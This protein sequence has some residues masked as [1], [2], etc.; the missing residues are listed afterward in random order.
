MDWTPLL[1][2]AAPGLAV[3]LLFLATWLVSLPLRNASIA[4]IVW[5]PGFVVV[6]WVAWAVGTG[7]GQRGGEVRLLLPLLTTVWGIRLAF[8]IARRNRGKGEDPRYAKWRSEGGPLWPLRSLFTV[9]LLQGSIL[10]VV[11]LP[12]QA[13]ARADPSMGWAVAGVLLF[14]ACFVLEAAA[15]R[16]LARFKADP[17][18]RGQVLDTGVWRYSRHPNYFCDAVVWWGLW[19]LG[20]AGTGEW[21]TV[22][23]PILMTFLLRFVS[24][25]ALLERSLAERRPGY[26][27]Y[28]RRTSPFIPWPPR[29]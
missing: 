16:Q 25:V 13:G 3:V 27:E 21:W 15:D 11:S 12:L 24:G 7:G 29:R 8:H 18:N 6:A 14:G 19:A 2:F 4:D 17:A 9:F 20:G 5:G 28:M 22:V 26:R 23:G 1:P 10:W